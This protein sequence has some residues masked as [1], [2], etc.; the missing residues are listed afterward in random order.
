MALPISKRDYELS[1]GEIISVGMNF[2]ALEIMSHYPGG[3][4]NLKKNMSKMA[5]AIQASESG[6]DASEEA[7]FEAYDE[8]LPTAMSA[9]A[10]ML[11]A[12]ILAGGTKC[13]QEEAMM[14]IGPSDFEQLSAIFDEFSEA[15]EKMT[16][17]NSPGRMKATR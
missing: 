7:D 12:L 1:S 13:T 4:S 10:Y 5:L 14:A 6:D 3:L 9:M 17:K 15:M 11:H 2:R 8:A 16:G